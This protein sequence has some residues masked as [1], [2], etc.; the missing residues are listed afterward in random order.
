MPTRSLHR[1]RWDFPDVALRVLTQ[2]SHSQAPLRVVLWA[3]LWHYTWY[4]NGKIWYSLTNHDKALDVLFSPKL[5]YIKHD[6][7]IYMV[8]PWSLVYDLPLHPRFFLGVQVNNGNSARWFTRVDQVWHSSLSAF[9]NDLWE[10][11]NAATLGGRSWSKYRCKY[12]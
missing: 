1:F 7:A 2:V 9:T 5:S 8:G 12:V 6:K 11:N 3:N 4:L 10:S